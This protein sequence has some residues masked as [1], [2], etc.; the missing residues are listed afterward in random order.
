MRTTLAALAL[1]ALSSAASAGPCIQRRA[2]ERIGTLDIAMLREA[3]GL[4][5][6]R[7]F[8]GRLYLNNDS[9]DGPYFYVMESQ[10][11]A[12]A[13]VAVSGFAAR[14]AEGIAIGPCPG[15]ASCVWLGDIGDNARARETVTFVAV[16]ES[17]AFPAEALP[18]RIVAARYPDGAHDAEAFAFHPNGDLY[19]ITKTMQVAARTSGPA[20]V[21][22]LPAAALASGDGGVLTF[23]RVGSIDLP[24]LIAEVFP[25]QVATGMDISADGARVAILTYR[26]LLEWNEDLSDGIEPGSGLRPGS[27]Y[28]LTPLAPLPQAEAL[29]YLPDDTGVVYTS[30]VSGPATEA[31]LYR[32]ACARRD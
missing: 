29:A 24:A 16:S 9:G 32:Q 12:T 31:P 20:G 25:N 17:E 21:Y 13:R 27:D 1:G 23:E 11:G 2:P 6:S 3:S 5:A 26:N 28:T 18:A 19:L 30:E 22:R 4:A 10:G 7:A 8:P 14:D 15:S